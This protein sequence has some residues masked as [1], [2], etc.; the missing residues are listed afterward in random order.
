MRKTGLTILVLSFAMLWVGSNAPRQAVGDSETSVLTRPP[1]GSLAAQLRLKLSLRM[2]GGEDLATTIDHNRQEWKAL[3]PEQRER[4]RDAVLAHYKKNAKA[5]EELLKKYNAFL[6]LDKAKREAYRRRAKWLR[7]VVATFSAAEREKLRT[8][9]A[10][11][12]AKALIA[13]RDDLVRQGKLTLDD[14]PKAPKPS[15]K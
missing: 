8:M 14:P 2:A 1:R 7:I 4:F 10:T 9:S 6:S 5:Q 12:R 3:T 15:S 13:R 11:D